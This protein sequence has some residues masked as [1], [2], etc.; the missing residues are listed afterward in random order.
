MCQPS[1]SES[2]YSESRPDFTPH[3]C[4]L[5]SKQNTSSLNT[6]NIGRD[7]KGIATGD[8]GN[9]VRYAARNLL[10]YSDVP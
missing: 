7:G 5:A 2:T 6:D 3:I 4:Y 10:T 1:E 8:Y 9:I